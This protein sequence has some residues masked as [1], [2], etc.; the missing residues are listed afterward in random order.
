MG[1]EEIDLGKV[2][3]GCVARKKDVPMKELYGQ[4]VKV[5]SESRRGWKP[6]SLFDE[7][8]GSKREG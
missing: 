7:C 3:P 8:W 2:R 6:I 5:A 4:W 1:L